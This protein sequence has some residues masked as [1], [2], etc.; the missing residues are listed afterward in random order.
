MLRHPASGSH[1]RE[2]ALA[3]AMDDERDRELDSPVSRLRQRRFSSKSQGGRSAVLDLSLTEGNTFGET[4]ELESGEDEA[5]D[6]SEEDE[7]AELDT[8]DD[9]I[10]LPSIIPEPGQAT[11]L[12]RKWI[13]AMS[14]GKSEEIANR[15]RQ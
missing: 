1:L 7:K 5:E 8:A 2:S 9:D 15:F 4:L 10:Q 13:Q 3:L 12:Q 14:E 11:P 6:E